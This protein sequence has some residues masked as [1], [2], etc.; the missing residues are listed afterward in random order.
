MQSLESRTERLGGGPTKGHRLDQAFKLLR[1]RPATEGCKFSGDLRYSAC[2]GGWRAGC[3]DSRP[4]HVNL[5]GKGSHAATQGPTRQV[6]AVD[7]VS[8]RESL[9]LLSSSLRSPGE[10]LLRDNI[11]RY[12]NSDHH[13][14]DPVHRV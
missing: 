3:H 6:S 5:R 8:P 4:R 2:E 14:F 12:E 7:T 9:G 10:R 11:L 1:R 13:Q